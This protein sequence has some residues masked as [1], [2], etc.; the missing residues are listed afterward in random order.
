[1]IKKL[2]YLELRVVRCLEQITGEKRFD[3]V[4]LQSHLTPKHSLAL[5]PCKVINNLTKYFVCE[6][7]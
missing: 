7:Y 4:V 3:A 1:M 2:S 5:G 6:R